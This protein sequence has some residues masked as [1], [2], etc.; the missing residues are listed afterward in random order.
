MFIPSPLAKSKNA[1]LFER[2]HY[3]YVNQL[4]IPFFDTPFFIQTL[5]F[6]VKGALYMALFSG[7][8]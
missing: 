3:S 2:K 7:K 5:A 4:F 8:L 6:S 1:S